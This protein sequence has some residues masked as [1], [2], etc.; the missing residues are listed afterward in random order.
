MDTHIDATGCLTQLAAVIWSGQILINQGEECTHICACM[1]STPHEW[2]G[3]LGGFGFRGNRLSAVRNM[4]WLLRPK[5]HIWCSLA[6]C[7]REHQPRHPGGPANSQPASVTARVSPQQLHAFLALCPS[8]AMILSHTHFLLTCWTRLQGLW[9]ICR[10]SCSV[11]FLNVHLRRE[12]YTCNLWWPT[13]IQ[14]CRDTLP[15]YKWCI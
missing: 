8:W 7:W 1:V 3:V 4:S 13:R 6:G 12:A 2:V 9:Q 10:L 5:L 11:R 14:S 15:F